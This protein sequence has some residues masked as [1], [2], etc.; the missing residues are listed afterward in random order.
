[1][2]QVLLLSKRTAKEILRD[3]LTLFFGLGFPLVL[4]GLLTAIQANVPEKLFMLDQLAPG[5]SVFGLSFLS[6]F[7][8][9]LLSKDRGSALLLRLFTTPLR[10]IHYILGYMLP[11]VPIALLQTLVCYGFALI[12]GL[13]WTWNLLLCLAVTLPNAW[14]FIALGLLFGSLLNEKQVGGVC[15][16]LLTNVSVMSLDTCTSP[17][18]V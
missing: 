3:P 16:A 8:A 5:I 15:G 14:I 9:L 17:C 1:M 2:K 13:S 18:L 4:L 10:P 11:L 6:L 7:S 12:L